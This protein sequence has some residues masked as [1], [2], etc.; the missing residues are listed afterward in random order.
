MLPIDLSF[1]TPF[2]TIKTPCYLVTD[3]VGAHLWNIHRTGFPT[4]LSKDRPPPLY[5]L[6]KW[7]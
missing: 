2:G 1:T 5:F 4:F 7:A 6:Q 3:S